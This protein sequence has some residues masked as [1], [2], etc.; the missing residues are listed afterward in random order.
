[1]RAIQIQQVGNTDVMKWVEVPTPIPSGSQVLVKMRAAGVNYIDVYQRAGIYPVN[2]PYILGLEGAGVVEAVG[3]D[4][5]IVAVGDRVAFCNAPGA[6][7]EY[8]C[9]PEEKLVRIPEK[10][11]FQTAAACML[12]GMTAHYL[13]HTTYALKAGDTCIVHSAAGGVGLLLVQ[14]AKLR[15]ARVIAVVSTAAKGVLAREAGADEVIVSTEKD[16]ESETM[17]LTNNKGVQVVYDGVGK[18]TFMRGINCLAPL[19]MMAL[20]G[21]SS[22][23]VAPFDPAILAQKGSLFL[24]RPVLFHYTAERKKLEEHADAVFGLIAKGLLNIRISEVIPMSQAALAHQLLES[25]KTTGKL[26]LTPDT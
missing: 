25:R 1:M 6:Y 9:A 21:Q 15:G 8:V 5:K 7:A 24:T 13:T 14:V 23:S 10:V 3:P 4:A 11:E 22:G 17:R 20:Y 18:D 2:L 26:L 12:Q 19:G 16:F